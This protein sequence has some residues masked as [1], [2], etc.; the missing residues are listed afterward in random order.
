MDQQCCMS[1][2]SSSTVNHTDKVYRSVRWCHNVLLWYLILCCLFLVLVP[3]SSVCLQLIKPNSNV[4]GAPYPI[5]H[6][7]YFNIW[8]IN[9]KLPL[10]Q[11]G[12]IE[13][14]LIVQHVTRFRSF[15]ID[16][17]SEKFLTSRLFKTVSFYVYL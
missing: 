14:I 12:I 10:R 5:W 9:I 17:A 16:S 11:V 4:I 1:L 3:L 6:K 7:F 8:E 15:A 2:S 13:G